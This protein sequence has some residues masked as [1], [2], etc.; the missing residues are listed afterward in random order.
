M[1]TE[2]GIVVQVSEDPKG[3]GQIDNEVDC[4]SFA[5]Q[6]WS[7]R[8]IVSMTSQRSKHIEEVW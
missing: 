3:K 4:R 7:I 1:C 2:A 5:G 6:E 8:Y